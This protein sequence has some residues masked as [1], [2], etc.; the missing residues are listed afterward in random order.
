MAQTESVDALV[1]GSS[2]WNK[3]IKS[4][5]EPYGIPN[6]H[7]SG[8]NEPRECI[9]PPESRSDCV[10]AIPGFDTREVTLW[11]R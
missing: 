6:L 1:V 4:A 9:K 8:E 2:S 7:C 3:E 11:F 10:S 5:A